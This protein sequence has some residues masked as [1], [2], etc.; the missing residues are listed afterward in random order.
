[1]ADAATSPTAGNYRILSKIADGGMGTVYRGAHALIGRE[2]AIKVLLPELTANRDIVLRFFNEAK[3][4]SAIK[5]PGIVEIFDFGYLDNG[6]AYIVMELLEGTTLAQRIAQRGVLGEGEAAALL[7]GVCGALAAAHDLGIVHRDLKPDNIFLVPDLEHGE[8]CKLLDFGIAKLTDFGAAGA[9]TK[10]GAVM[11]TP[12]YMSPEQCRGSGHVDLR[13]DLYS[14]GCIFYQLVAGRPPFANHGAGEV[15]GQHLFV[16]PEPPSRHRAGITPETEALIMRLLEKEPAN[17][18]QSARELASQLVA[19]AQVHGSIPPPSW[20]HPALAAVPQPTPSFTP[21]SQSGPI[22]VASPSQ[23]T[24]LSGVA[25]Q[26]VGRTRSRVGIGVSIGLVAAAIG[27]GVFIIGRSPDRASP[28]IPTSAARPAALATTPPPPP[29][30]APPP[31]APVV[32]PAPPPP[33]PVAAPAPPPPVAAK[34]PPVS[35]KKPVRPEP[36]AKPARKPDA[37]DPAKPDLPIET[38]VE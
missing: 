2:V 12:T 34:P 26:S 37:P 5:H 33:A 32:A 6:R 16:A 35:V 25:S 29:A 24:T 23:P 1:M 4:T 11:G 21:T 13:A 15:I 20:S 14:L 9:A 28:P 19:I 8:R 30:P 17:R 31:P 36:K 22:P 3:A 27:A 18:P 7:R 38:T 10:T